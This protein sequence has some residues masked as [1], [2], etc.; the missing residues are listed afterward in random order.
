MNSKMACL[1]PAKCRAKKLVQSNR[2]RWQNANQVA[3]VESVQ[4]NHKTSI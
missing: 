1:L 2:K 3:A 4:S